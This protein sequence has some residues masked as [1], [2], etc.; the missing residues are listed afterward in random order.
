MC[1]VTLYT[2]HE[3]AASY[4]NKCVHYG[5]V[6]FS[7]W[8]FL[9]K[10]YRNSVQIVIL[11]KGLI[12]SFFLFL[13][14]KMCSTLCIAIYLYCHTKAGGPQ[15]SSAN[16][17]F[18]KYDLKSK[19]ASNMGNKE[20]ICVKMRMKIFAKIKCRQCEISHF[21]ENEKDIFVW[22]LMAGGGVCSHCSQTMVPTF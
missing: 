12:W 22:T 9:S 21:C 6:M 2:L 11:W 13:P 14:K 16:R 10:P 5:I 7:I 3:Y 15:I 8:P 1:N 20:T 17:K 19:L 18:T 4:R